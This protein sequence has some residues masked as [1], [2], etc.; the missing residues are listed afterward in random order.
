MLLT[1]HNY[2][3]LFNIIYFSFYYS[4]YCVTILHFLPSIGIVVLLYLSF[5][6]YLLNNDVTLIADHHPDH[7]VGPP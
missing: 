5:N 2:Q 3:L 7:G 1:L 6:V 4:G